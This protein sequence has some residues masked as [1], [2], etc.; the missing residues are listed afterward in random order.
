VSRSSY[1]HVVDNPKELV[2]WPCAIVARVVEGLC[3]V[4]RRSARSATSNIVEGKTNESIEDLGVCVG[5][6]E[7]QVAADYFVLRILE[8]TRQCRAFHGPER[9]WSLGP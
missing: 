1:D 8:A 4:F 6:P 2:E 5:G 7:L 3:D 9:G